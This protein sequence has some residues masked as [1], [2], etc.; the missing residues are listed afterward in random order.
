MV[1]HSQRFEQHWICCRSSY[2]NI[3]QVQL[4]CQHWREAK[5]RSAFNKHV[6]IVPLVLWHAKYI[7]MTLSVVEKNIPTPV[8]TCLSKTGSILQTWSLHMVERLLRKI[9][10]YFAIK[11]HIFQFSLVV[12]YNIYRVFN[13]FENMEPGNRH[14]VW[15]QWSWFITTTK[16]AQQR[17]SFQGNGVV[18]IV[19]L[20]GTFLSPKL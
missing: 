9:A 11:K 8:P 6:A 14:G 13:L 16:W 18:S 4:P 10:M 12:R 1:L 2:S 15:Q 20:L 7:S 17:P 5:Q 19:E 3:F